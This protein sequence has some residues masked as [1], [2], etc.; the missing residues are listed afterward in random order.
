MFF[1]SVHTKFVQVS[2]QWAKLG[3]LTDTMDTALYLASWVMT[4]TPKCF[5]SFEKD[6]F[7]V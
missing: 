7:S 6:Q 3:N 5:N 2:L 4:V 1:P